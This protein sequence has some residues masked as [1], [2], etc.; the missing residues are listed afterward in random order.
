MAD[1]AFDLLTKARSFIDACFGRCDEAAAN[2][3]VTDSF[4]MCGFETSAASGE[5]RAHRALEEV[6]GLVRAADARLVFC[7]CR[8][9]HASCDHA[10]A[11]SRIRLNVRNRAY[12]DGFFLEREHQLTIAFALVENSWLIEHV[13][14]SVC[15]GLQGPVIGLH[16]TSAQS[17]EQV[18]RESLERDR[19]KIV[20]ELTD[21]VVFEYDVLED[22]LT[23]ASACFDRDRGM[24]RD[25]LV[26]EQYGGSVREEEFVHP[27]DLGRYRSD[28]SMLELP[29]GAPGWEERPYSL[30]YRLRPCGGDGSFVEADSY[31]HRRVV[32]RRFLGSD[33]RPVKHVGKI[34]DVTE[35]VKLVQQLQTDALTGAC[36][37]TYL[38]SRLADLTR[39]K[40]PDVAFAFLLVDVDCFKAVNDNLGHLIGDDVLVGLVG[41][42]KLLF[43]ESDVVARLGGD[44]FM[45]FMAD[46]YDPVIVSEKS[47]ALIEYFGDL[48][49]ACGA[50]PEVGLSVGE[51]VA[52]D[53]PS[54]EEVYRRADIALYWAKAHGKNCVARYE[55]GMEYPPMPV[56]QGKGTK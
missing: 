43:R 33:G 48:T 24:V 21:D 25:R 9:A 13:H 5:L 6:C 14:I 8:M 31:A 1:Q 42:A 11:V 35:E 52:F 7:E 27:D 53:V 51:V 10:L 22:R 32:G 20:A 18:R 30:E 41:I 2:A 15:D 26:I 23:L 39:A 34:M 45:V 12:S 54:F 40:Q 16:R 36:N 56:E 37:R 47:A 49:C 3:Y 28:R 17:M 38:L 44:E 50:P 4:S 29:G 46:V 55:D 19:Y